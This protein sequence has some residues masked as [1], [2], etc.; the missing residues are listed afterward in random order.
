MIY[1]TGEIDPEMV[2]RPRRAAEVARFPSSADCA[3]FPAARGVPGLG[4]GGVLEIP[5]RPATVPQPLEHSREGR[6][7]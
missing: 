4:E 1:R 6:G 7:R 5:R 3:Q 2:I